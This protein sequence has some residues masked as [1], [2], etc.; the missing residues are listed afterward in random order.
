MEDFWKFVDEREDV[1][2]YL[3]DKDDRHK[4]PRDFLLTVKYIFFKLIL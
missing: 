2:A 4:I 1:A 3:P